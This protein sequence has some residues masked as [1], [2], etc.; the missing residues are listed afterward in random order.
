[1]HRAI[2]FD[3]IEVFESA[4][5]GWW[6]LKSLEDIPEEIR[7]LIEEIKVTTRQ[8]TVPICD[9]VTGKV[10]NTKVIDMPLPTLKFVSKS[11]ALEIGAR[12]S[13]P[14]QVE[15]SIDYDALYRSNRDE[16]NEIEGEILRIEKQ[17]I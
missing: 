6:V 10:T 1:M 5:R 13:I 16:P 2:F 4:G 8:V 12:H 9:P 15:V 7:Q 14:Q 17:H 3:P 11:K